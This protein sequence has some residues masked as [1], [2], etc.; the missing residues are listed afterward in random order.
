MK[1]TVEVFDSA[2]RARCT[3]V[4]CSVRDVDKFL[5]AHYL[6]K[7]PGVCVLAMMM[8]EDVFAV[9]AIVYALPPPETA[10]RYKGVTWEMARLFISD[11]VPQNGESWLISQSV[12]YIKKNHRDV[13]SL[14]TYADP[15][16]GH[17]GTVYRASNWV[18]DGQTDEGRS[19]PRFDLRD[20]VT[21]KLYGRRSHVPAGADTVRAPRVS[22]HRFI[23]R[24]FTA[25]P[26]NMIYFKE[27]A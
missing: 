7:R 2:W 27:I 10:I 13:I 3:V 14:V 12:K 21:G 5:K 17:M 4:P 25:S 26:V 24:M 11:R 9:G 15:S 19:T 6:K 8:L 1:P 20:R 22:K 16:Q 23:Y 18:P